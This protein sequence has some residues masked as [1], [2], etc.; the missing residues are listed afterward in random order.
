MVLFDD[1]A[2][3]GKGMPLLAKQQLEIAPFVGVSCG[4]LNG[5]GDFSTGRDTGGDSERLK[6]WNAALE[7]AAAS[8]S[9]AAQPTMPLPGR[10][11]ISAPTKPPI[12]SAQRSGEMRS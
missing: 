1:F 2:D 11:T 5:N 12:T 10:I 6:I 4:Q 7:K 3:G 8:G 9:S